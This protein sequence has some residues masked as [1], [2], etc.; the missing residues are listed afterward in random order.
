MIVWL[1]LLVW[2]T[3]TNRNVPFTNACLL[4]SADPQQNLNNKA[5]LLSAFIGWP[6]VNRFFKWTNNYLSCFSPLKVNHWT[7]C[8]L[9]FFAKLHYG[10][11]WDPCLLC[12]IIF[13]A[14][15]DMLMGW[16]DFLHLKKD[17]ILRFLNGP[18]NQT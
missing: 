6:K 9:H 3:Q 17:M 16:L 1:D 5:S 18:I 4:V 11:L 14:D 10:E 13:K 15:T 2:G 8:Q 7:F 12:L